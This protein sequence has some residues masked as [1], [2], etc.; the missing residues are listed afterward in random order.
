[1]KA[2]RG[3]VLPLAMTVVVLL[4]GCPSKKSAEVR[5]AAEESN[6]IATL[7]NISRHC[8]MARTRK[9]SYPRS[10]DEMGDIGI[11]KAESPGGPVRKGSYTYYYSVKESEGGVE[12]WVVV[13]FPDDDEWRLFVVNERCSVRMTAAKGVSAPGDYAQ[14]AALYEK[15]EEVR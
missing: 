4:C 1:M 14:A 10:L 6:A 13:A 11:P 12:S 8:E 15:A 9:G 3:A 2:T 7:M 5:R